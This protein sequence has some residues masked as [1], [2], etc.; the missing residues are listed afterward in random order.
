[1]GTTRLPQLFSSFLEQNVSCEKKGVNEM[2]GCSWFIRRYLNFSSM[3]FGPIEDD[4]KLE[5]EMNLYF[6]KREEV[7]RG[8]EMKCGKARHS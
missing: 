3:T 7:I 4:E 2:R 6:W 5:K 1:M 8:R